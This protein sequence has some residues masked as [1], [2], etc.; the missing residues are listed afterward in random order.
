MLQ[1]EVNNSIFCVDDVLH[2]KFRLPH[3]KR[4]KPNL[5]GTT[6]A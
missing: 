6:P 2:Y 5:D 3:L 1:N 4:L